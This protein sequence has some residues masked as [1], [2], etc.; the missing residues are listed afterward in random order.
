MNI[1]MSAGEISG[2]MLGAGL[3][4]ALKRIAP[5]VKLTGIGG[6]YM[7]AAGV[8]LIDD[9]TALSAA[10][11]VEPLVAIIPSLA[12]YGRIKRYFA[13]HP[14][15]LVVLIDNQG[16]NLILSSYCRKNGIPNVYYFPPHVGIW[17]EANADKLKATCDLIIAPF[18][19]DYD[20]Y[21][22]HGCTA[23]CEGHPFADI[24]P[25]K[26]RKISSKKITIGIMPG[27]RNQE[28]RELTGVFL[29][30]AV[31]LHRLFGE[32][33][34][35]RLPLAHARYRRAIE[36]A[37]QSRKDRSALP[38]TIIEGENAADDVYAS[39]DAMILASG[40][41]SLLAAVHGIPMVIC[42]RTSA[43]TYMIGKMVVRGQMIGMPNIMLGRLAVPEL[44]QRD[45]TSDAI[46]AHI[47]FWLNDPDA[48]RAV[49]DELAR[50]RGLLGKTGAVLRAAK[51]VI[52][53]AKKK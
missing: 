5:G 33:I 19:F 17:G 3:A 13:A 15:D 42:Y 45:C 37:I 7:R 14:V 39:A 26:V 4:K 48:Y 36:K 46:A 11:I 8:S 21:K 1:F 34:Q 41:A 25:G 52:T 38:L 20:V 16:F 18:K 32:R 31:K 9:I 2:D 44:I 53:C 27:S 35:F 12:A 30:A 28:I 10:G 24:A 49:R 50:V 43:L 23:I 22:K 6:D 51:A 47:S 40:T 29:D